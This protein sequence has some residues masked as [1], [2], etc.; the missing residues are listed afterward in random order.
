MFIIFPYW[1]LHLASHRPCPPVLMFLLMLTAST[2]DVLTRFLLNFWVFISNIFIA[3]RSSQFA[4]WV[5]L[6][7]CWLLDSCCSH[8]SCWCSLCVAYF[9]VQD[10]GVILYVFP[11]FFF[12]FLAH[13]CIYTRKLLKSSS[14]ILPTSISW[15]SVVKVWLLFTRVVSY[16]FVF[17]CHPHT[18]GIGPTWVMGEWRKNGQIQTERDTGKLGSVRRVPWWSSNNSSPEIQL[19]VFVIHSMNEEVASN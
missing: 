9:P 14:G 7:C 2:D 5:F 16:F 19:V 1:C 15:S 4:C 10:L 12:F 11:I 6:L 8:P 17:C 13:W 18:F 3:F